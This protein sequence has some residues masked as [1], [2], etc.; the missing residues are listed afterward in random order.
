MLAFEVML[1]ALYAVLVMQFDP[2]HLWLFVGSVAVLVIARR[3]RRRL[4][5]S[6]GVALIIIACSPTV[7]V[8]GYETVGWRHG[9][10]MLERRHSSE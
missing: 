3:R 5:A 7:I 6:I 10:E 2:F 4:G 9:S 1:F 8:V